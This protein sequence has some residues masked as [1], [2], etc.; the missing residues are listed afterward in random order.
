MWL[1]WLTD[2]DCKQRTG[3]KGIEPK[4]SS[5]V[6]LTG[7]AGG[8]ERKEG[9]RDDS[10]VWLPAVECKIGLSP[11]TSMSKT[12]SKGGKK[13]EITVSGEIMPSHPSVSHRLTKTLTSGL[14]IR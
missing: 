3:R 4:S 14:R 13:L 5:E 9:L 12:H 7:P 11:N 1:W 10:C 2:L 6:S 8:N